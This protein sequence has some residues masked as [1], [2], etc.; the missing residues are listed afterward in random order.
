[1][2]I[3][4]TYRFIFIKTRKT[5]GS[6]VE[7]GLSRVCGPNDIITP[8]NETAGEEDLRRREGGHPPCNWQKPLREHRSF[9]EWRRLLKRRRRSSR[10]NSHTTMKELQS[11]LPR[12]VLDQYVSFTIERNP[13]D[14]AVSRYFW[15]KHRWERRGRSGFPD[16]SSYLAYLEKEKP[17]W[18]S[19]WG[20]Y[21][22]ND[23][24]A[25]DHVVQ[26]DNLV[27]NLAHIQKDLNLPR[28]ITPP[29]KRAKAGHREVDKHYSELL[30]KADRELISRVCAA[31]IEAFGYVYEHGAPRQRSTLHTHHTEVLVRDT[32]TAESL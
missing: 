18:L 13:W 24:I 30:S 3:C 8:L 1:M 11:M 2:I 4:H 17:H 31:E 15:Q 20:H 23:K 5:A 10:F 22:I 14:K 28:N 25:V 16:I 9:K 12:V 21:T 6:S 7:I 29:R 26:Y 32:S 19:N 27:A